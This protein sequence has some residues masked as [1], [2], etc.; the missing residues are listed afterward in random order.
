M[1]EHSFWEGKNVLVTG[2]AGFIGSHLVDLLA[3]D[4]AHVT[5]ADDLSRG[6]LENLT[7]SMG[8][9]RFR[10]VDLRYLDRC[11]EV[12]CGQDVIMNLASPTFGVEYSMTHHAEMLT[13][14]VMIGFNMLEAARRQ[15]AKRFLVVSSSCVYSDEAEI[16]TREEESRHGH[17]ETINQGYGW[18]K[19]LL[20]LQGQ[21]YAKEYGMEVAIAR[22]FN[23]YGP[24]EPLETEKAHVMPALIR[25]VLEGQDPVVVWGS[26]NQTRSFVHGK[27]FAY[28][29]KLITEHYATADPVNLGHDRET[30]I[31]ELIRK[32][33]AVAGANPRVVFDTTK[34]EGAARKSA[35]VTKLR[36]VT[37]GFSPRIT[38]EEGL[39]EM[40][41][42]FRRIIHN[43]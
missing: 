22:P 39:S 2:G 43:K 20:E 21:Y 37:H 14:T 29:L 31:R 4:K 6:R 15:G 40:I 24:R 18:G 32:I 26:G 16:P 8:R 36:E 3:D 33:C 23:A 34:P 10:E 28:G 12:S 9:I 11:E 25:K 42:Y 13:G 17:P 35:D 41:E 38:L 19:R 27:D 1:V 30:T 7:Q 5:V